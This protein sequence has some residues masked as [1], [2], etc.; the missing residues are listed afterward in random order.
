M[1]SK[2][3]FKPRKA[4]HPFEDNFRSMGIP[5]EQ[6]PEWFECRDSVPNL[7]LME[8]RRNESKSATPFKTWFE[9]MD[10]IKRA[11]FASGNYLPEAIGLEFKNFKIFFDARKEKLRSELKKVLA[12]TSDR[13]A[14]A[15]SEWIG[16]DDEVEVVGEIE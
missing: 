6:W 8:G 2:G 5:K 1:I 3:S 11:A 7:Q 13:V 10:D 4:L 14:E 15:P 12:L 9:Q 16:R